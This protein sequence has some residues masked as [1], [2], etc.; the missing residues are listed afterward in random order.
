MGGER[1]PQVEC[2][3]ENSIVATKNLQDYDLLRCMRVVKWTPTFRRNLDSFFRV[4][5]KS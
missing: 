1:G 2:L 3:P 4:N 5:I